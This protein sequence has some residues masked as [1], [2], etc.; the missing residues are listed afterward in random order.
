MKAFMTPYIEDLVV[1]DTDLP[2]PAPIP[3]G[4]LK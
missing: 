2:S 4:V 1:C 3:A